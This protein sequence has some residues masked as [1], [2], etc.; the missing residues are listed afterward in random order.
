MTI[1]V[2]DKSTG[3]AIDP[4]REPVEGD[5]VT[6]G[7]ATFEYHAPES[8]NPTTE[9]A[10][11]NLAIT[12][13]GSAAV[14]T[15]TGDYDASVGDAI[16]ITGTLENGSAINYG[17]SILKLPVVLRFDDGKRNEDEIYFNATV[18]NGVLTANGSFPRG[19][20]WVFDI[21]RINSAIDGAGNGWHLSHDNITF[22]VAV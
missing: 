3:L 8:V 1:I 5:W 17:T 21:P 20:K 9:Y 6:D 11:L 13:G 14:T 22:L 7:A 15:Y 2:L 18:V 19:G 4:Q 10:I 12:V 16:Q